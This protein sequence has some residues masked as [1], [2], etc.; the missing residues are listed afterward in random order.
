[1]A[2]KLSSVLDERLEGRSGDGVPV[3]IIRSYG[4]FWNP[5]AVNWRDKELAGSWDDNRGIRHE[6]NFWLAKGIYVLYADFKPIY[7]GKALAD[8]SGVGKRLCDHL[9]DRLVGRW[10]MFS[11]Y[12]LHTPSKTSPG[13]N[14]VGARTLG[15]AHMVDTLEAIAIL[16]TDPPLNRRRESLTGAIEVE[17]VGGELRTIRSY[18]EELVSRR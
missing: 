16:I 7:V 11:W 9:S 8:S 4:E 13:V 5:D 10:D 12:S 2:P 14:P 3:S 6:N 1:M 15:V 18:L 17:Q